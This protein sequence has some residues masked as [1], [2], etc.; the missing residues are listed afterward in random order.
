M[1]QRRSRLGD[2]CTSDAAFWAGPRPPAGLRQRPQA[3]R[4]R[5]RRRP[6]GGAG[7][8]AERGKRGRAGGPGSLTPGQRPPPPG[9][10]AEPLRSSRLPRGAP[11]AA[12][13]P[14]SRWRGGGGRWRGTANDRA[15]GRLAQPIPEPLQRRFPAHTVVQGQRG[16]GGWPRASPARGP[17]PLPGEEGSWTEAAWGQG[18][19]VQPHLPAARR[20]KKNA[21]PAGREEAGQGRREPTTQNS[22]EDRS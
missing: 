11:G 7:R 21:E 17:R 19:R 15:E 16:G 20:G 1:D 10:N 12:R 3:A 2:G 4:L 18:A 14:C 9:P 22:K 5:C 6:L 8:R 13:R